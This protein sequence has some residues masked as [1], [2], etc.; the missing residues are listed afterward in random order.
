MDNIFTIAI[1]LWV[2][3]RAAS[4]DFHLGH[5]VKLPAALIKDPDDDDA[6]PETPPGGLPPL[7][8]NSLMPD[9]ADDSDG[10]LLQT[11]L[12]G[13]PPILSDELVPDTAEYQDG[14]L[15]E[16]PPISSRSLVP[17]DV[18]DQLQAELTNHLGA[19]EGIHIESTVRLPEGATCQN[20]CGL[21]FA[22]CSCAATC[23]V[24][25]NCCEDFQY[26]CPDV[27]TSSRQQFSHV[28]NVDDVATCHDGV[29]EV[30][31]CP[32]EGDTGGGGGRVTLESMV[33]S[34]MDSSCW[35]GAQALDRALR[36]HGSFREADNDS[37][38]H[39]LG[40]TTDTADDMKTSV[41]R[42]MSN[43]RVSDRS[44]GL[45]YSNLSLFLCHATVTSV[46]CVWQLHVKV[47][48]HQAGP[49]DA[50]EDARRTRFYQKP[51]HGIAVDT[52]SQCS[53]EAVSQCDKSDEFFTEELR[54]QCEM[55]TSY[56]L[57]S[58]K[59]YL[60]QRFIYKNRF[61]LQCVEGPV[62][63]N[64]SNILF[65]DG[66]KGKFGLPDFT[67][68]V[69]LSSDTSVSVSIASSIIPPALWKYG[70]C[71]LQQSF[72]CQLQ[73]CMEG[74]YQRADGTCKIKY[75][76]HLA[77]RTKHEED[78]PS[79]HSHKDVVDVLTC[80]VDR[81]LELDIDLDDVHLSR[82]DLK[83]KF[84]MY[85][86][87][88]PLYYQHIQVVSA[89]F[90]KHLGHLGNAMVLALDVVDTDQ[91]H[92]LTGEVPIYD[93]TYT[94]AEDADGS[95]RYVYSQTH[96]YPHEPLFC[97][98]LTQ[99]QGFILQPVLNCPYPPPE[100]DPDW[101]EAVGKVDSDSCFME[102]LHGEEQSAVNGFSRGG[103]KDTL[104]SSFWLSVFLLDFCP[105]SFWSKI[106]A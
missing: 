62:S 5:F 92:R 82:Y 9:D 96:R 40:G 56:V 30:S 76:L 90:F 12:G 68:L 65:E 81:H 48:E 27:V 16:L 95:E 8:S 31:R 22:G 83:Q 106:D 63:I 87:T 77:M 46:P 44:N 57:S 67:A 79:G 37:D 43:L 100:T 33:K 104:F 98:A 23:M 21:V 58:H 53:S 84:I 25:R 64:K 39:T 11:R 69:A 75:S 17:D 32:M 19:S 89:E 20:R 13:L 70:T 3:S 6:F 14:A 41:L 72:M 10:A 4:R 97:F 66:V 45:V 1:A 88:V 78:S 55:L 2:I 29:F 102:F 18:D 47:D 24:Y 35:E 103:Q 52:I 61:C 51:H 59:A 28:M 73:E 42:E 93:M 101:Q 74:F 49:E 34:S 86:M 50:L 91:I 99:T 26:E 38:N 15:F 71:D 7:S 85:G 36:T 54:D 94:G 105:I 60:Y 80:L